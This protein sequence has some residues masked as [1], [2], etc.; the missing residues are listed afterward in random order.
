MDRRHPAKPISAAAPFRR[1]RILCFI[2]TIA[3]LLFIVGVPWELPA[4]LHDLDALPTGLSRANIVQYVKAGAR[5]RT[6]AQEDVDEIYGLLHLATSAGDPV[7]SHAVALDASKP[8][9]MS[10]YAGGEKVDWADTVE[11]LKKS[12]PIVVFSKTYCPYSKKAKSLL[13]T[14]DLS[15]A[16]KI[17]EV[18]LRDDG[19]LIKLILSRVTGRGT[20]PN[21]LLDGKSLGGSD[22]LQSMHSE[23][24]LTRMFETAGLLKA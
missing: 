7:L 2:L 18:D 8:I 16:P 17:I 5:G 12:Y 15:P 13:A 22:D 3:T 24:T 21:V 4:A 1:R 23:G 19:D 14:Y 11:T 9:D 20:F 10:V 6:Q